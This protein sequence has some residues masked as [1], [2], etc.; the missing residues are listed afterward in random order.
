MLPGFYAGAT[1]NLNYTS[2]LNMTAPEYLEGQNSSYY[3]TGVDYPSST[4]PVT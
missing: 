4:T 3:F 1:L 2:A